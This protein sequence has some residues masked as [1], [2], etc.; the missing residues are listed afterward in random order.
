MWN[1]LATVWLR[2]DSR[3]ASGWDADRA[4]A[5]LFVVNPLSG[6]GLMKLFS[7]HPPLE[8]RIERLMAMNR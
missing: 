1:R 8:E 5:H 2:D 6:A 7:T 3:Q 4:P